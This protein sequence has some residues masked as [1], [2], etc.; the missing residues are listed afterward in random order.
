MN[1]LF[2]VALATP[3]LLVACNR[4]PEEPAAPAA[5]QARAYGNLAQVMQAI[6]FPASNTIFDA[7]T[8]DPAAAK[9]PASDPAGAGATAQFSGVYGGWVAVENAGIAL[10][11]TA[12]LIL[13]PGRTCQNGKPVPSDQ[14]DFR[15]WAANLAAVGAE[16]QKMAQ[17]K[18]WNEDVM[19]D[20]GGKVSDACAMCHEKYR[21][22]PNQPADRC[23]P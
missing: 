22:T 14:E 10:Q 16:V 20:I 18:T 12:N 23:T 9:E 1:R 5:P 17:G 8:A 21:D 7:Q 3:F 13:I 4:A 11:E 15:M 2:G 19:L 6:P